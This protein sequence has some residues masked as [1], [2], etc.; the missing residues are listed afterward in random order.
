VLLG[1]GGLEL[2]AGM[3]LFG[4]STGLGYVLVAVGAWFAKDAWSEFDQARII[5][6]GEAAVAKATAAKG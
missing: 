1:L 2:T 5:R 3:H 6:R 4:V